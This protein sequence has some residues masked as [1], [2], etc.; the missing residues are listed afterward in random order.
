MSKQTQPTPTLEQNIATA[1]TA[2]EISSADLETLLAETEAAIVAADATAAVEREKALDP[3]ASLMQQQRIRR[4]R[5]QS[6]LVTVCAMCC[7]SCSRV[8]PKL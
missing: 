8:W 7:Q 2:A 3:L 4:C 5:R 6:L 1:L